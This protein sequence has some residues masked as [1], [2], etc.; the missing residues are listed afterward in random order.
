VTYAF[1]VQTSAHPFWIRTVVETGTSDGLV[2][3]EV[4][5]NGA[6]PGTVFY[7]PNSTNVTSIVF[8]NC[9]F[10][11]SMTGV[12]YTQDPSTCPA[13]TTPAPTTPAPTTAT[14]T[15]TPVPTTAPATSAEATT[16]AAPTTV[17]PT[18][19]I[20]DNAT[21]F[22]AAFTFSS[23]DPTA[24]QIAQGNVTLAAALVVELSAQVALAAGVDV[25]QVVNASLVNATNGAKLAAHGFRVMAAGDPTYSFVFVF[26][27]TGTNLTQAVTQL[28]A[29]ISNTSS[30]FYTGLSTA[31]VPI[32]ISSG[33]LSSVIL[34]TVVPTTAAPASSSSSA[35]DLATV[36]GIA[37]AAA[38]VVMVLVLLLYRCIM[39][40]R[41][42]G[43]RDLVPTIEMPQPVKS[44]GRGLRVMF[45]GES[46]SD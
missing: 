2:A 17:G 14:P 45:G 22:Q 36:V 24:A 43:D 27:I 23:N 31:D 8:Y 21:A 1:V 46:D 40:R 12:I 18:F 32:V 3:P 41:E 39:W 34:V 26:T 35:L 6:A 10:H 5:N 30:V 29:Q 25:S 44:M 20:P 15:T 28:A 16:T 13:P 42:H 4:I 9:Q 19:A 7:T 38:I 11:A 33:T 37:V